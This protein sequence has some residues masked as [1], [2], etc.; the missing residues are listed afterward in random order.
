MK[1]KKSVKRILILAFILIIAGSGFILYESFD[2]KPVVKKA[3]VVN[4][5]K[6][7]GYTLKSN[8][9]SEYK[10][11]FQEL[12]D[13]LSKDEVDEEEYVKQ[14]GKMFVL[15]FY[16]LNDKLT[17]TDI[18]GVDFVNS[19]ARANFIA[20]AEDTMY[21]YVESDIYGNRS[22]KLPEVDEVTVKSVEVL[23][24]TIGTNQTDTNAYQV[25]LAWTYKEDLGYQDKVTL[26]FTHEDKVLSLVE[27]E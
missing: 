15:D 19:N 23:E 13:I 6:D 24:Y 10:K 4:E 12:K 27:M 18:G 21:K 16:T 14:I 25:E 5:I 17:N 7:Y 8:K 22:Q 2:S 20:K 3:K 9:S 11:M 1:L 26:I